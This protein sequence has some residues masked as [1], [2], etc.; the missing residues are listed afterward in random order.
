MAIKKNLPGVVPIDGYAA[1]EE[2]AYVPGRTGGNRIRSRFRTLKRSRGNCCFSNGVPAGMID[3]C[4]RAVMKLKLREKKLLFLRGVVKKDR[5]ILSLAVAVRELDWDTGTAIVIPRQLR[6]R[7]K[8][9]YRID[10]KEYEIRTMELVVLQG[11]LR[12]AYH[13][14]GISWYSNR[15]AEIIACGWKCLENPEPAGVY[16]VKNR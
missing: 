10:K 12:L 5:R 11:L 8:N 1:V 3:F 7:D 6:Y 13:R 14:K 16:I 15:A 2:W 9:R 4:Y